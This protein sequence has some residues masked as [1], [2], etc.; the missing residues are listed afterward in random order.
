MDDFYGL[1]YDVPQSCFRENRINGLDDIIFVGQYIAEL[2]QGDEEPYEESIET[3]D[4]ALGF[5]ESYDYEIIQVSK[6][7]YELFGD[8]VDRNEQKNN[9][10][11]YE[12]EQ[13]FYRL[14]TK[15]EHN[16]FRLKEEK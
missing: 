1:V 5:L 16:T 2:T 4:K 9:R 10:L 13:E 12:L 11:S 8:L 14:A 15:Y 6:E 3:I 7:N